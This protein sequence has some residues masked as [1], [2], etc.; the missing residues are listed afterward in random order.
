MGGFTLTRKGLACTR[1]IK[2][3]GPSGALAVN[4]EMGANTPG[5]NFN[6]FASHRE[7][8]EHVRAVHGEERP[9]N[10]GGRR[11]GACVCWEGGWG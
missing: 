5:T 6:S 10:G 7:Y 8:W 11:P 3:V 9:G 1:C 4:A 2:L